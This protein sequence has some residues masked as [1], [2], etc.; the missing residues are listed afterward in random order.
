MV[1][2]TALHRRQP[3]ARC[4]PGGGSPAC[5]RS[6][7]RGVTRGGKR[8]GNSAATGRTSPTRPHTR[9]L[10]LAHSFPPPPVSLS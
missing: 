10:T 8:G 3:A 6:R 2:K 9:P 4:P 7:Q 5:R 1:A